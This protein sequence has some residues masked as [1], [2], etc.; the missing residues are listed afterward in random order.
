MFA[1]RC[2]GGKRSTPG[3]HASHMSDDDNEAAAAS[4]SDSSTAATS[5]VSSS[6]DKKITGRLDV[7]HMYHSDQSQDGQTR[8]RTTVIRDI[9]K[10]I[11]YIRIILLIIVNVITSHS[12][13]RHHIQQHMTDLL[14]VSWSEEWR[15]LDRRLLAS[16]WRPTYRGQIAL[17][18]IRW[19]LP[20]HGERRG[21]RLKEVKYIGGNPFQP[22]TWREASL[23]A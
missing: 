23:A 5:S 14:H 17:D 13:P 18:W 21:W 12:S 6:G 7:D 9:V 3:S 1:G 16:W 8:S 22:H 4:H 10:V 19:H 15:P 2:S 11:I 20:S